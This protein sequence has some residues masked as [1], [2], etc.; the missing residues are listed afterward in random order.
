MTT[1]EILM[2]VCASGTAVGGLTSSL[3]GAEL[4]N[5]V[6][7]LLPGDK[8]LYIL[9]LKHF[10]PWDRLRLWRNI[11]RDHRRLRPNSHLVPAFKAAVA[12]TLCSILG[13]FAALFVLR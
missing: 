11:M 4:L 13:L 6:A 3:V 7:G 8:E 5:D 2:V 1:S 12:L 9:T 10:L